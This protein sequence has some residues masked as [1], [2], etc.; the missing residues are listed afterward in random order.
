MNLLILMVVC[1]C[2]WICGS[3]VSQAT[4]EEYDAGYAKGYEDACMGLWDEWPDYGSEDFKIGYA[5]GQGERRDELDAA[6]DD[7]YSAD[8]FDDSNSDEW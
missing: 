3:T 2:V 4:Y 8:E 7:G 5:D 6:H 1:L